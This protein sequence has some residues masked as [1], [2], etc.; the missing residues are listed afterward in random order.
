MACRVEDAQRLVH[1]LIT[2]HDYRTC[3]LHAIWHM[4]YLILI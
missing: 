2:D 1:K 4:P 3:S